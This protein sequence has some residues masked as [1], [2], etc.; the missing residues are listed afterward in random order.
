MDNKMDDYAF[1]LPEISTASSQGLKFVMTFFG[2]GGSSMNF[3]MYDG[4]KSCYDPE[5]LKEMLERTGFKDV[6]F[7]K[8]MESEV[9]ELRGIVGVHLNMSFAAEARKDG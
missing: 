9:P 4:H 8:L 7:P 1:I 6:C 2:G 5:S 3:D